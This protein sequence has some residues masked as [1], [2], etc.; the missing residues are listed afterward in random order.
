MRNKCLFLPV[1]NRIVS[2]RVSSMNWDDLNLF[3]HSRLYGHC[4]E[5][6][7]GK[8]G[9]LSKNSGNTF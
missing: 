7:V 3:V 8:G 5:A 9:K 6:Y 1:L 4:L 2:S